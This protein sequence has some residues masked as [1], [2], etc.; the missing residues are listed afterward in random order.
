MCSSRYAAALR[1]F[2]AS[3]REAVDLDS[4]AAQRVFQ[5]NAVLVGSAAVGVDGMRA[6][7]R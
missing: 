7:E 4:A 3:F 5:A 6:R 1:L 2:A